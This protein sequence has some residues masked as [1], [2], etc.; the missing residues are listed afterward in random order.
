MGNESQTQKPGQWQV[1]WF[2]CSSPPGSGLT[3]CWLKG[4]VMGL[5]AGRPGRG[6]LLGG[7]TETKEVR[8]LCKLEK[9]GSQVLT[10]ALTGVGLLKSHGATGMLPRLKSQLHPLLP[11]SLVGRSQ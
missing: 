10:Q 5:L 3:G 11:Q 1:G 8:A 9:V 2:R 4:A 6:Q 7:S